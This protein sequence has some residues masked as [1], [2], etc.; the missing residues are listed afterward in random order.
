MFPYASSKEEADPYLIAIVERLNQ[1]AAHVE[2]LCRLFIRRPDLRGRRRPPSAIP[3]PSLQRLEWYNQR[4]FHHSGINSFVDFLLHCPNLRYLFIESSEGSKIPRSTDYAR[5]ELLLLGTLRLRL[6]QRGW[7]IED[8]LGLANWSLP[9]LNTLIIDIPLF[10]MDGEKFWTSVGRNITR[11]ELGPDERFKNDDCI[12]QC[13]QG[14]P[15]L[16]DLCYYA[17]AVAVP[18]HPPRH[19]CLQRVRI[20]AGKNFAYSEF[21]LAE[22][23]RDHLVAFSHAGMDNLKTFDLYGRKDWGVFANT[24]QWEVVDKELVSRGIKIVLHL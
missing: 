24:R 21:A 23:L 17:W 7:D 11:V 6:E 18:A 5:V 13:L 19:P 3:L 2:T 20:R 14:C 9:A 4:H 8:L 10:H 12:T 22:I 1:F 15:V 16:Q